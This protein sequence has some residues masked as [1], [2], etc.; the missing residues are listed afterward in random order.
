MISPRGS[1][2]PGPRFSPLQEAIIALGDPLPQPVLSERMLRPLLNL[3][4][5]VQID[6]L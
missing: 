5:E 1:Q 6:I 4:A 2:V 3:P